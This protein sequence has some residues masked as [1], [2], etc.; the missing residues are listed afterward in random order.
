M[1]TQENTDMA[2]WSASMSRRIVERVVVQADLVLRSP[3]RLGRMKT[4]RCASTSE[5]WCG[6]A[7]PG[8]RIAIR[9]IQDT[10]A[11][12]KTPTRP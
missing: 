12:L 1:R 4:L 5:G 2:H 10:A 11:R 6:P 8:R 3:A 9:S 7:R